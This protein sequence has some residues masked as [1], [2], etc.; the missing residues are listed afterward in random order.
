MEREARKKL[1][2]TLVLYLST[3]NL[4]QHRLSAF[5]G[6]GLVCPLEMFLLCKSKLGGGALALPT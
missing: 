4:G 5:R 6:E 1:L 3:Y 2:E